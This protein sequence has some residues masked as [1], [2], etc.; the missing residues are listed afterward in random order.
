MY[1]TDLKKCPYCGG[2]GIISEIDYLHK[3]FHIYCEDCP[4]T[5]ELGFI[6]ANLGDGSFISFYEAKRA[7]DEL[8][9]LWNRRADDERREAD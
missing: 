1:R 7:M 3:K 8:T 2:E 6:D 5:M 9:E 4:A